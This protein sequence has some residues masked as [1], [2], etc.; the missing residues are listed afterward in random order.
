[1]GPIAESENL[2]N[3][4]HLAADGD[5]YLESTEGGRRRGCRSNDGALIAK[6]REICGHTAGERP[7]SAQASLVACQAAMHVDLDLLLRAAVGPEADLVHLA[8]E[9]RWRSGGGHAAG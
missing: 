5:R 7:A 4:G 3:G 9:E 1:M 8:G 2:G 6:S